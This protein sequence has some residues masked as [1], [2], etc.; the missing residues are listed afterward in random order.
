MYRTKDRRLGKSPLLLR[1]QRP[2]KEGFSST[3]SAWIK[4]ILK[5]AKVEND[6]FKARTIFSAS[7]SNA[8]LKGLSFVNIL[9]RGLWPR[10]STWHGF[11]NKDIICPKENF[12]NTLLRP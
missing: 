6:I 12:Q 9:K 11:Y 7:I 10:K 5:L 1:F 8:K 3:I 4:N 2:Y